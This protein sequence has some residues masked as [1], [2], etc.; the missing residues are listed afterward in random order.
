MAVCEQLIFGFRLDGS[1]GRDVLA[2]SP[3]LEADCAREVVA[4]CEGWGRVP[5][6]GVRRAV[7][8]SWPLEARLG[9]IGGRLHA[10]VHI[11]T[12]LKPLYHALVLAEDDFAKYGHDPFAL[13]LAQEFADLVL[14]G[15]TLARR[16]LPPPSSS[17]SAGFA[18][19]RRDL[20][21]VDEALR[22]LLVNRRLELPLETGSEE[23][24]RFLNLL[25]CCLPGPLRRDLRFT[26]W[27]S[28]GR[29][30]C[31]LAAVQRDAAFFRAWRPYL[32]SLPLGQLTPSAE[33]YVAQVRDRLESGDLVGLA[34]LSKSALVELG[35]RKTVRPGTLA[36]TVPSPDEP[37]RRTPSSP[38]LS[39]PVI[40]DY[41]PPVPRDLPRTGA[42]SRPPQRRAETSVLRRF[43]VLAFVGLLAVGVYQVWHATGWQD[44]TAGGQA[45]GVNLHANSNYGILDVARLHDDALRA[46]E[47]GHTQEALRQAA[48]L[49]DT[50]AQAYLD[51]VGATLES[52][53]RGDIHAAVEALPA[54]KLVDKGERLADEL[55]RLALADVS[56]LEG[57]RWHDL[58]KLDRRRLAARH[59]SVL[60][61]RGGAPAGDIWTLADRRLGEVRSARQRVTT[62]DRVQSLLAQHEWRPGWERDLDEAG[63]KL[64]SARSGG[65]ARWSAAACALARLKQ[66]EQEVDFGS[67]ALTLDDPT[68]AW[69]TGPVA[70][71]LPEVQRALTSFGDQ[72]P[73]GLLAATIRFYDDLAR[74]WAQAEGA[75][76]D[77]LAAL[78]RGLEQNPAV[79][80]DRAA[81]ADHVCRLGVAVVQGMRARGLAAAAVPEAIFPGGRREETLSFLAAAG[82]GRDS[83]GWQRESAAFQEPFFARWAARLARQADVTHVARSVAFETTYAQLAAQARALAATI[84]R[85]EDAAVPYRE[86]CAAAASLLRDHP[87]GFAGQPELNRR[88]RRV[89]ALHGAVSSPLPLSLA[90]VTVRLDQGTTDGSPVLVELEVGARRSVSSTIVLSPAAPAGSGWVGT[91]AV[92]WRVAPPAG[93][94]LSVRV[95]RA[96]DRTTLVTLDYGPWLEETSPDIL[97]RFQPGEGGRV[98]WRLGGDYWSGLR[99]PALD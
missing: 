76:P 36:A 11:G 27:T 86:L 46:T 1:P 93:E 14:P 47:P 63:R 29:N 70:A 77:Q 88:W 87:D 21:F 7:L 12:G 28:G 59:D 99:L 84:A 8:L 5:A 38:T 34:Q 13:A 89:E 48:Q 15:Q 18:P 74:G 41:R 96:V 57:T 64:E 95:L 73:P 42:R 72:K 58:G 33:D 62:L 80:F 31:T 10:V 44:L 97:K 17:L 35:V 25:V 61:A 56:L 19:D 68:A 90:D 78:V 16:E 60:T 92:N 26:S 91:T 82:E 6:E 40:A 50:Q 37:V 45:P 85:R 22:Q 71:A 52:G 55:R 54:D 69:R 94:H 79:V 98:A 67:A 51:Q 39:R 32:M 53:G 2:C 4:L 66:A 9:S 24:D 30:V 20:G 83:A 3:G 75:P 81:Y 49:L 65:A 43:V 23:S